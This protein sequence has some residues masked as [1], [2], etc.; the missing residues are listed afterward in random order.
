MTLSRF[1]R[2]KHMVRAILVVLA[3]VFGLRAAIPLLIQ[4]D[5]VGTSIEDTLE[6]WT[7]ADVT[8]DSEPQF[9]F[10]PY[11]RVTLENLRFLSTNADKEELGRIDAISATFD[12]FGAVRG[13]PAFGDFELTRPVIHLERDSNGTL[14][15]RR[16]GWLTE[17]VDAFAAAGEG[18]PPVLKHERMGALTIVDGT[19]LAA[20]PGGGTYRIS[21]INGRVNWPTISGRIDLTASG[22]IKG[23]MTH[24]TIDSDQP[25]TLLAGRNAPVRI[26]LAADPVTATFD[27]LA[28]LST[29]AFLSGKLQL[30]T[31]S[32]GQLLTWQGKDIP[33]VANAGPLSVDARVTAENYTAKLEDLHLGLE[34]AEASGVLDVSMPPGRKPQVGGTLAFDRLDLRALLNALSPPREKPDAVA[35]IDTAF[36]RQFGLDLRLSAKAAAFAPFTL[37]N[38]GAGVRIEDG[39][40]SFDIGDSTVMGGSLAG[41]LT[42]TDQGFLGGGQLQVNLRDVDIGSIVQTLALQGPLPAGHGSADFELSTDRPLAF[43]T[44]SDLTG[45]FRLRM[46]QGT[47]TRFNRQAFEALAA[48]NRFFNITQAGDGTFAFTSLDIEARLDR[49]FAELTK[50]IVIGTDKTL[51][52]SGMIPYR[53][54]S[55]AL[56][57]RL[58][59][60]PKGDGAETAPSLDF[61]AGG[62]WPEPVIS[63]LSAFDAQ[64]GK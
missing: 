64:N 40:A 2:S 51:S 61:F 31:P 38:L 25:L 32:L 23:E 49:G 7:G 5:L 47:L 57:G 46:D 3:V 9:A 60:T 6:A 63:P 10:W 21:D 19:L 44:A 50:A 55:V 30:S 8:V 45:Q 14:N 48:Q 28:N 11:P 4:T 59:D 39:R 42:L 24:W 27:G 41:R 53:T 13:R 1:I 52:V 15:W 17:A 18:Q 12:L 58:A 29:D 20:T 56:A 34:N 37:E 16:G 36:I 33:A 35:G 22:V 62:S 26:K 54:G 43:T